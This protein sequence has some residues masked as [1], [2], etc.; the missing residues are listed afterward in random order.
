MDSD[1]ALLLHVREYEACSWINLIVSSCLSIIS[2]KLALVNFSGAMARPSDGHKR[3]NNLPLLLVKANMIKVKINI[4]NLD[5]QST[6]LPVVRV[7]RDG[8]FFCL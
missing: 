5:Q 3:N 7:L 4:T 1:N 6:L 2:E 8:K